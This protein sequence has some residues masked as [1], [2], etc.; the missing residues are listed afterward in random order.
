M[1]LS[2]DI[3]IGIIVGV[4]VLSVIF[5]HL[6]YS[7][8]YSEAIARESEI[9]ENHIKLD[10][11]DVAIV[12]GLSR[13]F[14]EVSIKVSKA[15]VH[16]SAVKVVKRRYQLP[17]DFEDE[18]LRRFLPED[19]LPKRFF[20]PSE[21]RMHALGSGVIISSDGYIV[22][23]NHVIEGAD[24]IR[25]TLF[26]GRVYRPVWIRT[27]PPTD[28]ALIK[29][30]AKDLPYLV[31]AD[32][33]KVK[34]GDIV[35]AV[36]NPFGLDHTV[37]QGIVSYI[38]RGLRI[39]EY[40][41]YIQTDAAIN[42][43]N[44]GGPLVNCRG[45]IIGINTAIIS[46]TAT[47]AGIG[48]AIP[49]N[50]VKFVVDQLKESEQVVRSYLGVT[51][52][53]LTPGLAETFGLKSTTT[54]CVVTAVMPNSPASKAGIRP[55]DVILEFNGIKVKDSDHLRD[56]VARTPPGKEV[57]IIV[58]RNKK[59]EEIEV[60]LEK[61]PKDFLSRAPKWHRKGLEGPEEASK[62]DQLGITIKTLD[63]QLAEKYGYEGLQGV[64]VIEIDPDS[65]AAYAGLNEGDLIVKVQDIKIRNVNDFK[66]AIQKY[67]PHKG[68]R[69]FVR[70][71]EGGYKFIYIKTAK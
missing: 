33:D 63:D 27:D 58:W 35:L 19:M 25:I 6:Y 53:D 59:K 52:E 60:K 70:M 47:Y 51:I 24:D 9:T 13:I 64:V 56:L 65:E 48:F 57:E 5:G 11:A 40:G 68:I 16:I 29:I 20:G 62:I 45:Q 26:D 2:K 7:G 55:E 67:P 54:G 36:G 22:T 42:P 18:F 69:L 15:V 44:S 71:P 39:T 21:E 37:T 50:T 31:F 28:V 34:V 3:L 10:P 32:S 12:E 49:S 61:M 43:G 66:E 17:F 4:F 30:R 38:G 23:N 41:N 14:N 8:S 46:K 1:K